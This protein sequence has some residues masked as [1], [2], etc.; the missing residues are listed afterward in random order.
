METFWIIAIIIEMGILAFTP[1]FISKGIDY[2]QKRKIKSLIKEVHELTGEVALEV[3]RRNPKEPESTINNAIMILNPY[4]LHGTWVFD[5]AALG[6]KAEAFV[7]GAD[8]QISYLVKKYNINNP[9]AGFRVHI[10]ANWFPDCQAYIE[11]LSPDEYG[12]GN[13]Y[14]LTDGDVVIDGWYCGVLLMYFKTAPEKIY[15]KVESL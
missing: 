9:E 1:Y 14:R 11:H 3:M 12:S 13:Y 7:G 6:L 4:W 10:S 5:E 8:K 2:Y 15:C